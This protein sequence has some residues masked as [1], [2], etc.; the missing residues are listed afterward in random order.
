[1]TPRKLTAL[2]VEHLK[3]NGQYK[4]APTIESFL[5]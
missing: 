4:E 1:M 5:P 2:Y 3:E